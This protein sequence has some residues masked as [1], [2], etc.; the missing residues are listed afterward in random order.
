LKGLFDTL[1]IGCRQA[2]LG[3]EAA[4]RPHCGVVSGAQIVEFGE[5]SIA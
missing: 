1:G 3:A 2:I 4:V 5:K